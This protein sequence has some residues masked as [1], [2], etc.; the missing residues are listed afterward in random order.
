MTKRKPLEWFDIPGGFI[1]PAC[2]VCHEYLTQP[3]MNEALHS[4]A[5]ENGAD[6]SVMVRQVVDRYHANRH[7][8]AT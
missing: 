1:L 4:V 7:R 3:W 2:H 8:E 5:I 6:P